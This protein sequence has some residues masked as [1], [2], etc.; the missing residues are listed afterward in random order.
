MFIPFWRK[1]F[2]TPNG[3]L[4]LEN[5][6]LRKQV[7]DLEK[8]LRIERQNLATVQAER[9]AYHRAVT[10]MLVEQARATDNLTDEDLD[11]LVEEASEL[12]DFS[13]ELRHLP[14]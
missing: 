10:A 14:H 6:C 7:E 3:S 12:P 2:S 9:D 13:E 11:R 5:E 8:A 4:R 1:L